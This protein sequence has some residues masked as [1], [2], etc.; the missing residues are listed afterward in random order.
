MDDVD[1]FFL[2]LMTYTCPHTGKKRCAIGAFLEAA[3]THTPKKRRETCHRL[4][5]WVLMV[6]GAPFWV[7]CLTSMQPEILLLTISNLYRTIIGVLFVICRMVH[8]PKD[9]IDYEPTVAP[10]RKASTNAPP[11]DWVRLR[12]VNILDRTMPP[13][14]PAPTCGK[15]LAYSKRQVVAFREHMG[16][17]ICVF[18]IGVTADPEERFLHYRDLN[19]TC[20]WIIH[21]EINGDLGLIHM[22]EAAL[23]SQFHQ[24]VGCR[25]MANTGGEGGLLRK[26][27]KGPPYFVYI[28]GGR[29]DQLKR[30]G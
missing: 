30:V 21:V 22:L 7:S 12:H 18:K 5:R 27:H 8:L 2:D 17:E 26:H 16:V 29:A 24:C 11:V 28:S 13:Q 25:N 20:M 14:V 4:E 23:I 9:D 10:L 19:F 1:E 15:I 6:V 3:E